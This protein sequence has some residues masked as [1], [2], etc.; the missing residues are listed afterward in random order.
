MDRKKLIYSILKELEQ[1]NVPKRIDYGL[2]QELWGDIADLIHDKDYAK[3]IIVTRGGIG[4]KVQ[5]VQYSS[6]KI[7]IDGIDYLE[8]NSLLAKAYKGVKELRDWIKL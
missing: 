8:A 4:H 1:G 3:N 5:G 2:E 6:A 7:T